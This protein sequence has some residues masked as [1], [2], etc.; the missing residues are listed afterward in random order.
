MEW[1]GARDASVGVRGPFDQ[2]VRTRACRAG[3]MLPLGCG[4]EPGT[5]PK[6]VKEWELYISFVRK[7]FGSRV[8]G[9]DRA[10][11]IDVVAQYLQ[12][13]SRRC[14]SRTL[15]QVKSKIKHCGLCYSHLLP[16]A[17]GE[18]PAIKRL[19]LA[20]VSKAIRKRLKAALKAA[21]KPTGP[22]RS[23]ALGRVAMGMLFSAYGAT[24]YDAFAALP[25][26]IACW[27]TVCVAMGTGCMRF[28]L[29]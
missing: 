20:M 15:E 18:G 3:P 26:I 25:M 10:W 23:L 7:H 24:S 21:G 9:R 16:T 1:G 14:N 17:K 13:R 2:P 27:L 19:Q 22:K 8:P 12:W 29:V 6:Y 4:V 28:F 5:A 11:R